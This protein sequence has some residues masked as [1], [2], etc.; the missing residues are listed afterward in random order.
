M[1]TS[2]PGSLPNSRQ[3]C[4]RTYAGRPRRPGSR[5]P[6]NPGQMLDP[7]PRSADRKSNASRGPAAARWFVVEASRIQGRLVSPFIPRRGLEPFSAGPD[8]LCDDTGAGA[9]APWRDQ[10]TR[11]FVGPLPRG[12][13]RPGRLPEGRSGAVDHRRPHSPPGV[14]GQQFAG[15]PRTRRKWC[16]SDSALEPSGNQT[17]D[18]GLG[19]RSA[20]AAA[21]QPGRP[22]RVRGPGPGRT[23]T[24]RLSLAG[25]GRRRVDED[26]HRFPSRASGPSASQ[27]P[28][29]HAPSAGRTSPSASSCCRATLIGRPGDMQLL[30]Q[31]PLAGSSSP[32]GSTLLNPL[33]QAARSLGSRP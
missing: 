18:A 9:P 17:R 1:S 14:S 16:T 12:R 27:P 33:P 32:S 26:R 3:A 25:H 28:L 8:R 24:I 13:N 29:A 31:R 23:E 19:E 6:A 22:Q 20:G 5:P 11:Q 30:G 15:L 21:L 2:R 7:V 10:P 4:A